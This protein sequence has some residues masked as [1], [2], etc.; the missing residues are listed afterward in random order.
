[1]YKEIKEKAEFCL[2]CKNKPCHSG[3]PLGNNTMEFIQYVK[4][5]KYKEAYDTLCN[6]TVLPAICGR[7]C[8]HDKQCEG[9]CIRRIKTHPVLIGDIEAFVGDMAIKEKWS[10]PIESKVLEN[11]KV[12]VVGSGP[13]G[14]TAAAF[15]AKNGCDITIYEKRNSLGGLLEHGIPE[16]RLERKV[17]D[18]SIEK[19]LDLGVKAVTNYKL[20]IDELE[21]KYDAILLAMGA[22]VSSKMN[23]EGE[24]LKGV[25][26]ANELLENK[27]F[28]DFRDKK[29]AVIGGGNVAIDASRTIKKLGAKKVSII[30]RRAEEQMPAEKK[31]IE[32][33][34]NDGIEFLLQNNILRIIGKDKVEKAECVKTELVKKENED[35]LSPVNVE[36]SNYFIDVDYVIM[37]VGSKVD[38][39]TVNKLNVKTN[40]YGNVEVDERNMTSKDK[41]FAS[42]DLIGIKATVA[43]A[44]RS[45]RDAAYSII[46]Y[47]KDKNN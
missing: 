24:N 43:W 2:G 7:I 17:V 16:F 27:E 22:N 5:E 19:I 35:R 29:V 42:G 26:G 4:N 40:K 6:T 13:A 41:I 18:K 38:V 31:E 9:S 32:A 45:G 34:K 46:N 21:A 12:A 1:M 11:R 33:A 30:Y 10:I 39:D 8:P 36:G 44:A 37:A 23:I 14:L 3:C 28:P 47:L 25:Y 20:N 15:L